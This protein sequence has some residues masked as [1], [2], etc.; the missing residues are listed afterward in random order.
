MRCYKYLVFTVSLSL[1]LTQVYC[2]LRTT[3]ELFVKEADLLM[4][5]GGFYLSLFFL[6]K[7]SLTFYFICCFNGLSIKD[8]NNL[9]C[10]VTVCS[11]ISGVKQRDLCSLWENG[12][13]HYQPT[14][15]HSVWGVHGGDFRTALSCTSE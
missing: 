5:G 15:S 6:Q 3:K 8:I 7:P 9:H 1:I 14:G 10:I 12:Q 2:K 13:K 11:M 4:S